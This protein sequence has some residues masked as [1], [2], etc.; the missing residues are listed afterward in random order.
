[1]KASMEEQPGPPLNQT[2]TGSVV[3]AL[4]DST[5]TKWSILLSFTFKKPEY[6]FEGIGKLVELSV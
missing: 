5:K 1:M 4:Y 6:D 3:G 2:M